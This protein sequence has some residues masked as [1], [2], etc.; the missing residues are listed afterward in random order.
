MP[1]RAR[2]TIAGYPLHILQRGHNKQACFGDDRDYLLYLSLLRESTALYPCSVHAFVLMTNHVHLLVTPAD[3]RHVSR[4][5]KRLNERYAIHFNKK[6]RRTGSVWEGR[7]KSSIVDSDAYL[8]CCQRYIE[9][10]PVRAGMT[11]HPG[12][13]AWS[14]YRANAWGERCDAVTPH[15]IYASL[16]GTD[17]GRRVAYRQFVAAGCSSAELASIR[18]AA[19]SSTALASEAFLRT[20]PEPFRRVPAPAG[21]PKKHEQQ[22]E[23]PLCGK[24]GTSRF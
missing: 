16:G 1:R 5:M 21:R 9:L 20:L 13:Y 3:P 15:G 11:A 19:T 2:M 24:P 22:V 4:A 10:N 14:S 23:I 8:L 18:T 7:F 6:Y 17:D 12:D